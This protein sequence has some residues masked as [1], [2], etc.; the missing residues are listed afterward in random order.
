[1]ILNHQLDRAYYKLLINNV[2]EEVTMKEEVKLKG[3]SITAPDV[4]A[5]IE[6][7]K[8]ILEAKYGIKLSKVNVIRFLLKTWYK[9]N[10]NG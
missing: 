3:L 8:D 4:L 7:I 1:M 5:D 9:V 6:D 2:T 10:N